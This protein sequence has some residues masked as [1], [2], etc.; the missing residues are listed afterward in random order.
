M[1]KGC[2]GAVRMHLRPHFF[3]SRI[4]SVIAMALTAMFL[5][6]ASTEAA[7]PIRLFDASEGS[8]PSAQGFLFLT[9]PLFVARSHQSLAAGAARLD[10][11][12]AMSEKA[13][14]FSQ[15]PPFGKHPRQPALD[16]SSGF[17]VS[18][19]ARVISEAH[20]NEHRA[21]FSIIVTAADLSAI[22][23][24]FW[25]NEVWA[26]SGP[27]FRHA[28]GAAFPTTERRAQF[29]LEFR[30]GRYRLCADGNLLLQG[31]LRRYES[32]GT[33]YN[34]PEFLFFGDDT[35]SAQASVEIS[36]ISA[37]PIPQLQ[38]ARRGEGLA[39]SVEAESGRT[40]EFQESRD[41]VVWDSL[42]SVPVSGGTAVLEIAREPSH[43]RRWF[44]SILR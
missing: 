16:G 24:G 41:L 27:D 38:I 20:G 15:I 7:P 14:W 33:P 39:L 19:V 9:D 6:T 11:T 22:E 40:I 21:G 36:R 2:E 5:P 25:T 35:T 37:G 31:A 3:W 18:F 1:A 23:L 29:D 28:E 4:R 30:E 10:S 34:I 42:A 13:G 8:L 12:P 44:R 17:L 32:F 43:D 26:Q